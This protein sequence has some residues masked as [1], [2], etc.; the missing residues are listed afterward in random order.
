MVDRTLS[1]PVFNADWAA[2]YEKTGQRPPRS[3]LIRALDAFNAEGRPEDA[4]AIDLGC[5]SGRDTI[6]IIRRGW[7]VLAVDASQDAFDGLLGRGDLPAGA[8]IETQLSRYE[9]MAL[10]LADLINAGFSLPLC[11]K[12]AFPEVW[13]KIVDALRSG[14]R[15]SG[16]LYGDRDSWAGRPDLTHLSKDEVL[17]YLE[18]LDVEYLEEEEDDSLTPRGRPKHWHIFHIVARKP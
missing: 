6:E 3:T 18:A 10:P 17:A 1:D 7:P 4:S 14:G 8:N 12:E 16:Q 11:G 2:Y 9:D 15:F 5:G 13:Q